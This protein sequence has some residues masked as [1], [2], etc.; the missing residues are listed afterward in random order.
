MSPLDLLFSA[1]ALGGAAALVFRLNNDPPATFHGGHFTPMSSHL[2]YANVAYDVVPGSFPSPEISLNVFTPT[3]T[4]T[5]KANSQGQNPSLKAGIDLGPITAD[6]ST[7]QA[8]GQRIPNVTLRPKLSEFKVD[9]AISPL[10]NNSYQITKTFSRESLGTVAITYNSDQKG[11]LTAVKCSRTF[12]NV[13]V[14]GSADIRGLGELWKYNL[15]VSSGLVTAK[16]IDNG[17]DPRAVSVFVGEGPVS[18]SVSVA[19]GAAVSL[20]D[21][22][23]ES[24]KLYGK[25]SREDVTLAAIVNCPGARVGGAS[26]RGSLSL[27]KGA[28]KNGLVLAYIEG[29]PFRVNLGGKLVPPNAGFNIAYQI[30]LTGSASCTLAR[31]IPNVDGTWALTGIWTN[32]WKTSRPAFALEMALGKKRK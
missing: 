8:K 21:W 29:R 4:F 18:P 2:A 12:K 15:S 6:L 27:W 17:K 7:P 31:E 16:L 28:W 30:S 23:P 9:L 26:L 10:S 13:N 25:L 1:G 5:A 14:V 20:P 11:F 24:A 22:R 32:Y 3:T 19:L